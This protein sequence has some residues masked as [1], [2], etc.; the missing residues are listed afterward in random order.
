MCRSL[1]S[2]LAGHVPEHHLI[3]RD[4]IPLTHEPHGP[5]AQSVSPRPTPPPPLSS[6]KRVGT[7]VITWCPND[8]FVGG[9]GGGTHFE[10]RFEVTVL[11]LLSVQDLTVFIRT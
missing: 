6:G 7:K 5:R 4:Q 3:R 8:S 1:G 10:V 11:L 9:S 2:R